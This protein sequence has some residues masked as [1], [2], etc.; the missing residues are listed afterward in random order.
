MKTFRRFF[1]FV[2]T[3]IWMVV[4]FQLSSQDALE[5]TGL[6]YKVTETVADVLHKTVLKDRSYEELVETL[7]P[8]VRKAAHMAEYAILYMLLFLSFFFSMLATRSASVSIVIA[9]IYACTDEFHQTRVSGRAGSFMDVCV[10][11]TGVLMAVCVILFIYSLWQ[12]S[13]IRK[14]ERAKEKLDMETD[15]RIRMA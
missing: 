13:H 15:E 9:F 12:G 8:Y 7:H 14:E 1:W 10:D 3:L 5:T 11:M 6:S 2:P 4:I